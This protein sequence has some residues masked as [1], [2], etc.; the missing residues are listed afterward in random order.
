VKEKTMAKQKNS[1]K[2]TQK[3]LG[4][5]AGLAIVMSATLFASCSTFPTSTLA[6]TTT[7]YIILGYLGDSFGSYNEAFELAKQKYPDTDAVIS[8]KATTDNSLISQKVILGYYAVKFTD[9][10]KAEK[11]KFL[12]I[13]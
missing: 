3:I 1:V 2:K 10:E 7:S 12:G 4:L 6:S 8:V 11:K 9:V 13:L 5:I